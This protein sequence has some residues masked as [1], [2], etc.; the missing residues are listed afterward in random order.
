M[1]SPISAAERVNSKQ[2]YVAML[3]P[4]LGLILLAVV[5]IFGALEDRSRGQRLSETIT[6]S[7]EAS[8]LAHELQKERGMSA[9][10][11][12]SSG[13]QFAPE[14]Q[15]QR[16]LTDETLQRL[17]GALTAPAEGTD[18]AAQRLQDRAA[19]LSASFDALAETRAR[20]DALD[21]TVPELAGYYTGTIRALLSIADD[22]LIDGNLDELARLNTIYKS[23]L[24]AKE[25]AGVERAA[26]SVGFGRGAFDNATFAWYNGLSQ[27]QF[28]LFDRIRELGTPA[29]I[30]ILE[31]ALKSDA[32]VRVEELRKIAAASLETG[33]VEGITGPVWFG[34]STA[35][36]GELLK[37]ERAIAASIQAA[38]AGKAQVAWY[39][40]LG[41]S[42][43]TSLFTIGFAV[44]GFRYVRSM[45]GDLGGLRDAILR[46]ERSEDRIEIP[47]QGRRDAIGQ[48]AR[49]L[50]SIS[51]NGADAARVRA[52][53]AGSNVPFLILDAEDREVFRNPAMVTLIGKRAQAFEDLAAKKSDGAIDGVHLQRSISAARAKGHMVKKAFGADAVELTAA[54]AIVEARPS[55]VKDANGVDIGT[56]IE[57]NDVSSVRA[58]EREV[59]AVLEGVERGEFTN[60]VE[61][62]DGLGFT[63]IAASGLNKQM[64]S[65]QSFLAALEGS[66]KAMASGD[67]TQRIAQPFHGDFGR[68]KD[69]VNTNLDA[70]VNLIEVVTDGAAGLQT[71]ISSIA[72]GAQ[73]LAQRAGQQASALNEVNARVDE[74][75]TA[76]AG[77]ASD[78][79]SAAGLAATASQ[80]SDSGHKV[81]GETRNAMHRI[82]ESSSKIVEIVSVIDAIAFQTNLLALNAAV[83]AA[84]AGESGKG[85]AVVASEVRTLAQRSGD[86][87]SEIRALIG[88]STE[89]VAEGVE[90]MQK[91]Q[92]ALDGINDSITSLS[93]VIDS[94]A[95]SS[96][97][98]ARSANEISSTASE[99]D[100][101]TKENTSIAQDSARGAEALRI[102]ADALLEQTQR[103]KTRDTG[104]DMTG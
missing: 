78:A 82:E 9:G 5:M 69:N 13:A 81:L 26:G 70:L 57:L 51:T 50:K 49:C 63:S 14:L 97:D 85:F 29:E 55:R 27:R 100:G 104:L 32:T 54:D 23:I 6:L 22:P 46:I 25:F 68:A 72:E 48:I 71:T 21:I 28:Y 20:I 86:A 17:A 43:V 34:A 65:I 11:V 90:L 37:L 19:Q 56:A 7:T 4:I 75:S 41:I 33:A 77:S 45:V 8:T 93:E 103:F 64:E 10:H 67:L 96:E 73:G 31:A 80:R 98:Q 79:K 84:R 40:V 92:T 16:A 35:Y 44:F 1:S 89:N 15:K 91:T 60:R 88:E 95:S 36:L 102:Q 99:L 76:I 47:A 62:I 30:S 3:A 38:A 101:L 61:L 59:T 94:I 66:L 42:L 52:A 58:L 53:V 12:G 2:I 24:M 74:M 18:A 87:A 39:W 83:E